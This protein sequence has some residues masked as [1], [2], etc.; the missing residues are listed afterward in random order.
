MS[1]APGYSRGPRGR[2]EPRVGTTG[3]VR[4]VA[5]NSS[6]LWGDVWQGVP[7]KAVGRPHEAKER[8]RWPR[9]CRW[10]TRRSKSS[11]W[12]SQAT[13]ARH[14]APRDAMAG[15]RQVERKE[16]SKEGGPERRNHGK[17]RP[18]RDEP[19]SKREGARTAMAPRHERRRC[20]VGGPENRW[21]KAFHKLHWSQESLRWAKVTLCAAALPPFTADELLAHKWARSVGAFAPTA[22]VRVE[23]NQRE[24]DST[25]S[26]SAVRVMEGCLVLFHATQK[27]KSCNGSLGVSETGCD[28]EVPHP[29]IPNSPDLECTSTVETSQTRC[30]QSVRG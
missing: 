15:K 27:A 18:R 12:S 3:S 28:G 5:K 6:K 2:R 24:W 19:T 21:P 30:R 8:L 10:R 4:S 23:D 13:T 14:E 20:P 11:G 17:E 25:S 22:R 26:A 29:E 7:P 1:L 9:T 16:R